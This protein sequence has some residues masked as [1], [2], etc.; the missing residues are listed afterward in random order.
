MRVILGRA[1][2]P[3]GVVS[4]VFSVVAGALAGGAGG[5]RVAELLG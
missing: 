5:G 2:R 4:L 1:M 3:L